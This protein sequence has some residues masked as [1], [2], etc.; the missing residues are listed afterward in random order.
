MHANRML[1]AITSGLLL[2]AS[3]ATLATA[4][5]AAPAGWLARL[6]RASGQVPIVRDSSGDSR[7]ERVLS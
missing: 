3:L 2:S 5:D 1:N 4:E 6:S 7:D